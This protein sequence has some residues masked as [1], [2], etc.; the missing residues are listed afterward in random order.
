MVSLGLASLSIA[1]DELINPQGD[2]YVAKKNEFRKH[3]ENCI[4]Q[5]FVVLTG[6]IFYDNIL[7][8]IFD[9]RLGMPSGSIFLVSN[10]QSVS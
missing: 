8:L 1:T 10:N 5:I 2:M 9:C 4:P 3:F 7:F 6:K